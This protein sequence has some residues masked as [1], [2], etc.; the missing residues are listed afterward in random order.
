MSKEL[1]RYSFGEEIFNAVTHIVGGA[2]GIVAL[3]LTTVFACLHHLSPWEIFSCILYGVSI[4]TLYTMSALYHF[5]SPKLTAKKIFRIL[6]HCTIFFMIAGTYTPVLVIGLGFQKYQP[7]WALIL[8]LIVWI[9]SILGIVFN[10]INMHWKVVK[11]LSQIVYLIAGWSIM[12]AISPLI[13][14]IGIGGFLLMIIGGVF[15]TV[16][17]L[18]YA[19]GKKKKW[20]HSIFHLFVLFGT[21][22]Q[23]FAIIFYVI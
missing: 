12:I 19:V 7:D 11:I 22:I 21:I 1:P 14:S 8:L 13:E 23:F 2:L 6:D 16:G 9:S 15:Y 3:V 10:A 20:M 18:F 17:A 5:L 4:I